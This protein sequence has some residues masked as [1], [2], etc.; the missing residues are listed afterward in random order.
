MEMWFMAGMIVFLGALNVWEKIDNK[1]E[2][3]DLLNRLASKSLSDYAKNVVRMKA[4]DV[5]P[6]AIQDALEELD[7]QQQSDRIPM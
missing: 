4:E 1:K 2:R 7:R 6:E 3:E 5:T